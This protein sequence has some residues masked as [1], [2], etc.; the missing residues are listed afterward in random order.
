MQKFNLVSNLEVFLLASLIEEHGSI[1]VA[2]T[3]IN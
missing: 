2:S 1:A 3:I